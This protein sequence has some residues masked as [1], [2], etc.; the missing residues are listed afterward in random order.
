M[1]S[2]IKKY[3]FIYKILK[4]IK[5]PQFFLSLINITKTFP[6]YAPASAGS[7][8]VVSELTVRGINETIPALAKLAAINGAAELPLQNVKDVFDLSGLDENIQLLQKCF[9]KYKC[10]KGENIHHLHLYAHIMKDRYSVESIIEIGLGTNFSDTASHM[11]KNNMP[12]SS[13]RGF[14]DFLPNAQIFGCDIDT[15]VLF[16][17]ERITTFY[18]DQTC[19]DTFMDMDSKMPKE[20]DLLIDDGLHAPNTNILSLLYGLYKIRVGGWVVIEDISLNA[21]DL[22]PIVNRLVPKNFKGHLF[23]QG[24]GGAM[25]AVQRVR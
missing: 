1:K 6:L 23:E 3:P 17:E 21:I 15:R 5:T 11:P 25:Y 13:Q 7:Y 20:I 12:G 14:R 9:S 8:K 4:F 10:L 18:V 24:G 19:Y 16:S 2:L 22:W